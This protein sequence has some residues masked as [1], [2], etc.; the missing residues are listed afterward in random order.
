M[1]GKTLSWNVDIL[2][3]NLDY[4]SFYATKN[5]KCLLFIVDTTVF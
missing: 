2:I 3:G 1:G 5:N 4:I